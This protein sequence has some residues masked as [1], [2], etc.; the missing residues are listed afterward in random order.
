MTNLTRA[1]GFG[2]AGAQHTNGIAVREPQVNW[3]GKRALFSMVVGAPRNATDTNVFFWQIYE[4]TLSSKA[5][6]R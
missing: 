6:R 2:L 3:D 5:W 4:L 1:M